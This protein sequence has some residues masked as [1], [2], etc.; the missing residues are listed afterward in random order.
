MSIWQQRASAKENHRPNDHRDPFQRDRARILHS[1]AFRRLQSKTQILATGNND[2][3]RTRL[4]HSLEVAQI[5]TGLIAQLT[6]S[7]KLNEFKEL[8]SHIPSDALIETLCLA[9]DIGHP[10]FGHGG[11]VALNYSMREHGGFEGNAQTFRIL[12][13]LE[14][15]T[16]NFGMDLTR[17]ALLGLL[18]YPNPT[19]LVANRESSLNTSF[20]FLIKASDWK[21]IKGLYLDDEEKFQ[22]VLEPFSNEEQ[23]LL[24][25]TQ[26]NKTRFKSFDASI[27]ELADDIAYAV[28]DLEDAI[29]LNH[30][31]KDMWIQQAL[32]TL[33]SIPNFWS[34]KYSDQLTDMLFSD[35][36]FQRKNAIG[37]MV[38]HLVTNTNIVMADDKFITPLLKY[39]LVPSESAAPLLHVLKTFVYKNVILAT[40]VQQNEFKG[41]RMLIALFEAFISDPQRL[42]P[43]T[44]YQI[45][46][47]SSADKGNA[48]RV[49]CDYI[50]QM[51][52]QMAERTYDVMFTSK[53]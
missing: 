6:F 19:N 38:N 39:N 31:T 43:N 16:Q 10:R 52:D 12:T 50:A 27:M 24:T 36:H 23:S 44:I 48:Y 9:H 32:P 26:N 45:Y 41:Q 7:D 2:F 5:G 4:T 34:Q 30:V 13:K 37:A 40:E 14:P 3:H 46:E 15:Y 49:I 51:S 22:W 53:L 42:L 35:E 8:E 11:E 28:H 17:R 1:S 20:P 33:K 18:K 47:K 25:E 21:P 29:V